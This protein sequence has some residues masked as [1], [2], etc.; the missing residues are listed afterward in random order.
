MIKKTIKYKDLDGKPVEGE[1]YFGL[2][3]AELAK[4]ELGR[5]GGSMM[6]HLSAIVKSEDGEAIISTFEKL[7]GLAVGL[8]SEDGVR[9][10][11]DDDIRN[12]FLQ[13]DAYSELFMELVTKTDVAVEFINGILP[14]DLAEKAAEEANKSYT[15]VELLAMPQDEFEK[16]A[17]SDPK[18]MSKEHLLLAFQ[19]KSQNAA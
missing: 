5:K 13:T 16:V 18:H 10:M 11:K 9:F 19:R 3:K 17:G 14:A 6:E 1:W 8:R 12:G 2:S 15:D 7:I 4:F